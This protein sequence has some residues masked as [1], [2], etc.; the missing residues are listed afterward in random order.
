MGIFSIS[1]AAP[2]TPQSGYFN[3][4]HWLSQFRDAGGIYA[5]TETGLHLGVVA[6]GRTNPDVIR[7]RAMILHL[8]AQDR[9]AIADE[10]RSREVME[11]NH[12]QD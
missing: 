5:L 1:A 11:A 2:H 3:P 8:T 4:S 7:A 12:G 6:G 10:L 9:G